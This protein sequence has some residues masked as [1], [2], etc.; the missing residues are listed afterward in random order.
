[1]NPLRNCPLWFCY[2]LKVIIIFSNNSLLKLICEWHLEQRGN[3][4]FMALSC[5]IGKYQL[6]ERWW[7]QT[8]KSHWSSLFLMLKKFSRPG[9]G[10]P[11]DWNM[12]QIYFSYSGGLFH[13]M[14]LIYGGTARLD[15]PLIIYS[16]TLY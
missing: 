11:F 10:K 8:K 13:E 6:I 9:V 4:S 1:M 5:V 3:G 16:F 12:I 7:K 15:W 14:Y 2:P